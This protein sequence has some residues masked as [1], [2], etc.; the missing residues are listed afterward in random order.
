MFGYATDETV[1]LLPMTVL[2]AHK[3]NMELAKR[4]RDGSMPWL[5]PDSSNIPFSWEGVD[6]R[7]PGHYGISTRSIWSSDPS[8]SSHNS[9]L[10]ATR[11]IHLHYFSST[12]YTLQHY[13]RS[14]PEPSHGRAYNI[15]Y[16]SCGSLR[17]RWTSRRR[18]HNRS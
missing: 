5:L 2:L 10:D 18:R 9:H 11:G 12:N 7:N 13:T 15:S 16:Q 8:K 3:L 17:Y 1:E 4:R 6:C 14:H